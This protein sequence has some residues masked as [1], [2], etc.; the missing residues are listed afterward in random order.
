MFNKSL[1]VIWA[2]WWLIL[3]HRQKVCT[4]LRS[5]CEFYCDLSACSFCSAAGGEGWPVQTSR[6]RQVQGSH[7]FWYRV[8][9]GS[10]P[11]SHHAGAALRTTFH[12][13]FLIQ[14]T[15]FYFNFL[16][17]CVSILLPYYLWSA[18][19]FPS[20][21]RPAPTTT[22]HSVP[23]LFCCDHASISSAFHCRMP[24]F[25]FSTAL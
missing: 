2:L 16:R 4:E 1:P 20:S 15:I 12:D 21:T 9:H 7:L 14:L 24:Q 3:Y 10:P 13:R 5:V 17:P 6:A 23:I 19:L 22:D 25:Y 11:P 8:S 18:G